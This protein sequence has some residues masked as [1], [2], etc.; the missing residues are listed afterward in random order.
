MC[1]LLIRGVKE[2]WLRPQQVA[3][4]SGNVRCN[5]STYEERYLAFNPQ[6]N[7]WSVARRKQ[8]TALL[9]KTYQHVDA[10]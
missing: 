5:G 9:D 1:T 6:H 4:L 7:T 10:N 8:N 2:D 3:K